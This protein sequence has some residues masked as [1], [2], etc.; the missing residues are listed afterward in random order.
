MYLTI[1]AK[2]PVV[3]KERDKDKSNYCFKATINIIEK[4]SGIKKA[5]C[6]C[7]GKN[8]VIVK[9]AEQACSLWTNRRP[10]TC[11]PAVLYM[12]KDYEECNLNEVVFTWE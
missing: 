9:Q 11:E 12:L 3:T 6:I 1:A 8:T 10:Y 5:T 2:R 7:Y 4:V